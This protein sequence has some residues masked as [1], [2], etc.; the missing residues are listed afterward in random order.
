MSC[1]P[2]SLPINLL[3]I[4]PDRSPIFDHLGGIKRGSDDLQMF[5]D[6]THGRKRRRLEPKDWIFLSS[7][8]VH[9]L[10][11]IRDPKKMQTILSDLGDFLSHYPRHLTDIFLHKFYT[12][13]ENIP[14]WR[15]RRDIFC[16]AAQNYEHLG[17]SNL[18]TT[19]SKVSSAIEP[20][21][22]REKKGAC[23]S[24]A[25]LFFKE[26]LEGLES[27]S[28]SFK[29]I[30]IH[31][32]NDR[33]RQEVIQ[34]LQSLSTEKRKDYVD[35]FLQ[36]PD[37]FKEDPNLFIPFIEILQFEELS[38]LLHGSTFAS[39]RAILFSKLE[40][41]QIHGLELLLS[42]DR[43]TLKRYHNW[44][45]AFSRPKYR[46]DEYFFLMV[47]DV[48]KDLDY[49]E[50]NIKTYKKYA[51]KFLSYIKHIS[52]MSHD[53][54]IMQESSFTVNFLEKKG[55]GWGAL[56]DFLYS[57]DKNCST[58]LKEPFLQDLSKL[59]QNLIEEVLASGDEEELESLIEL[60]DIYHA[61]QRFHPSAPLKISK[62]CEGF[63]A[64]KTWG[65]SLL[66]SCLVLI[67]T[68][69]FPFTAPK[70]LLELFVT[71]RVF[72]IPQF[73]V[74]FISSLTS[75]IAE[76][77]D[78]PITVD[79]GGPKRQC[80]DLLTRSLLDPSSQ[81]FPLDGEEMF[82]LKQNQPELAKDFVHLG[83]WIR[84]HNVMGI[85][86]AYELP[87]LFF[88]YLKFSLHPFILPN[89]EDLKKL[90]RL[91]FGPRLIN[92]NDLS[93]EES[94]Q[95]KEQL[96]IQEEIPIQEIQT[97]FLKNIHLD[98]CR[99]IQ[100]IRRGLGPNFMFAVRSNS[101]IKIIE[102]V[103]SG[104]IT[105]PK[106]MEKISFVDC[107]DEIEN[108]ELYDQLKEHF[109][110]KVQSF[111]RAELE[112]LIFS[113]TGS[114]ILPSNTSTI[115][116]YISPQEFASGSKRK[117]APLFKC[118]TCE[119]K[120]FLFTSSIEHLDLALESLKND[121]IFNEA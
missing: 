59:V 94:A 12:V 60:Q 3:P 108:P 28:D 63:D 65:F 36:Y 109:I 27:L 113:I 119:K 107:P 93:I 40:K 67:I 5:F 47:A 33:L 49:Y 114:M 13:L 87:H 29:K 90:D 9:R 78:I 104:P 24:L 21:L 105:A 118:S 58:L 82:V 85:P 101:L 34:I 19:L 66:P 91:I 17:L 53:Y 112:G 10:R 56:F 103:Q 51:G 75:R 83:L 74:K 4:E 25:K 20:V 100:E 18:E 14:D 50:A 41:P 95:L 32:R 45:E 96:C 81:Q 71:E 64:L 97:E 98:R 43:N 117:F 44:F 120:L 38:H 89:S 39:R 106:F 111:S 30:S 79:Q 76:E 6:D 31:L 55:T 62:A 8:E 16:Q 88:S 115:K 99:A 92:Q 52:Q 46:F 72:E 22:F 2:L 57:F 110:K 54:R 42:S 61:E 121:L 69:D 70:K 68:R 7:K 77:V 116:V 84:L 26:P 73:Q 35:F 15:I 11:G 102:W 86:L 37:E 80:I 48:V 23:I 1:P